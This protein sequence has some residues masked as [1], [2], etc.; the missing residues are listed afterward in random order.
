M[1]CSVKRHALPRHDITA[2]SDPAHAHEIISK[3]L[4]LLENIT[5]P[6]SGS[7]K[8]TKCTPP[9]SG[10]RLIQGIKRRDPAETA[11]LPQDSLIICDW[12]NDYMGDSRFQK[13]FE[14]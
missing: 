14:N 2:F 4:K 8:R 1:Q 6:S 9:V 7:V 3:S 10:F 13:V 11:P 5:D 12:S